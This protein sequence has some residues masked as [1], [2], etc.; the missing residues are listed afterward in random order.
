VVDP[1]T[2]PKAVIKERPASKKSVVC[3]IRFFH[4]LRLAPPKELSHLTPAQINA[5]I[6][7]AKAGH[8]TE[9]VSEALDPDAWGS[10]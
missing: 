10:G 5:Y 3:A 6:A 4:A 9:G 1:A 7:G 8:L 2:A